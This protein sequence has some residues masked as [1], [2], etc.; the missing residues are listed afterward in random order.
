MKTME[1]KYAGTC[2][3]CQAPIYK[4]EKIQWEKGIGAFCMHCDGDEWLIE[5]AAK[6]QRE[7]E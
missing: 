6:E 2:V 7:N 5:N 3:S 1:A 4:G